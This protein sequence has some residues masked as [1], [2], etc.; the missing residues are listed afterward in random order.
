MRT[1]G[2]RAGNPQQATPPAATEADRGLS[3]VMGSR[4]ARLWDAY[5]TR[6]QAKTHGRDEGL[7]DVFME[8]F[9]QCY[10]RGATTK[11]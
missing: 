9:A 10:D 8:Y 3:A 7:A 6:W 2:G 11:R 1:A 5:V 4:K